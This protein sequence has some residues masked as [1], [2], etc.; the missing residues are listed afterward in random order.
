MR[1]IVVRLLVWSVVAA[2][3]LPMVVALLVGLGSLLGRLG[4]TW[5]AVACQRAALVTGVAWAAAIVATAV[6]SG[7]AAIE[8]LGLP[9]ADDDR[10]RRPD[11]PHP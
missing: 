11:E 9:A 6:C 8:V 1:V 5:A 3:L 10:P 4:D 7:I 2:L